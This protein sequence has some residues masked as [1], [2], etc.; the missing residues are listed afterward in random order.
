MIQEQHE[1]VR[2]IIGELVRTFLKTGAL[3]SS[4]FRKDYDNS[5]YQDFPDS[6]QNDKSWITLFD[7]YVDKVV[8][9]TNQVS[10]YELCLP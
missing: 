10:M 6:S 4:L 9:V 5:L 7:N 8:A 2:L 1:H 3:L